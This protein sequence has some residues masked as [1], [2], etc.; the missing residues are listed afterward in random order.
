MGLLVV[1]A[2]YRSGT[3]VTARLA[4]SQNRDVF[5]IPGS[6]DNGKSIGTNNLIKEFAKI[7]TSPDDILMKYGYINNE[8]Q[9]I[10]LN[11]EDNINEIPEE[12][13]SIYKLITNNPINI[14]DIV[15]LSNI[16]LGEIMAKLTMLELNGKIKKISGNRYIR[17]YE[18]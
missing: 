17:I 1:E 15:R 16:K 6:L 10:K 12:Y 3:S 7:V 11:S 13:R 5:C 8:S 9:E 14:N 2:A 4:F 18:D